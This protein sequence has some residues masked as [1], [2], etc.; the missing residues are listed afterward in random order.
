MRHRVCTDMA[1]K[2]K[3][4]GFSGDCGYNQLLYPVENQTK[5]LLTWLVQKLPRSDEERAEEVLGANALL[6]RRI[7]NAVVNWKQAAWKLPC[8]TNKLLRNIYSQRRLRTI[9]KLTVDVS[10]KVIY[11]QASGQEFSLIPSFL[12]KHALEIVAE[13]LT[14]SKLEDDIGALD[15]ADSLSGSRNTYKSQQLHTLIKTSIS[16]SKAKH[17]DNSLGTSGGYLRNRES[18]Q[19]D[20]LSLSLNELIDSVNSGGTNSN[21]NEIKIERGT[22]FMHATEFA[23]ETSARIGGNSASPR[24]AAFATIA[25]GLDLEDFEARKVLQE[26]EERERESEIELLRTDLITRQ[27][28]MDTRERNDQNMTS[29]VI[30]RVFSQYIS[31][32]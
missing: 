5:A 22:R 4:L 17:S 10:A 14:E 25:A 18:K 11:D 16:S 29:K 8:C 15:E 2:I 31:F 3:E 24:S 9:P 1:T 27:G 12:E 13:A 21:N 6:N 30:H 32:Y 28:I 20:L 19:I 23:Q 26:A 7:V